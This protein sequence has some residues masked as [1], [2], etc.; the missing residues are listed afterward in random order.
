MNLDLSAKIAERF[1]VWRYIFIVIIVN[2]IQH[3]MAE[4]QNGIDNVKVAGRRD[5]H[6]V[7]DDS[8]ISERIVA[9]RRSKAGHLS[10]MTKIYRRLDEY[11]KEYNFLPEVRSE[12]HRLDTQ[13]K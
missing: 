6:S 1:V 8:V 9:L 3:K 4:R 7:I 2:L 10:E 12:T 5:L 13:W 11:L